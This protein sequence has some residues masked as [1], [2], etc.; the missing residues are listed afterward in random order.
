M[1]RQKLAYWKG[2]RSN[3]LGK[4]R[5]KIAEKKMKKVDCEK[6]QGSGCSRQTNKK[7]KKRWSRVMAT[8]TQT[9]EIVENSKIIH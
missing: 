3:R 1:N 6:L 7:K 4:G 8:S 2:R 9:E 5:L